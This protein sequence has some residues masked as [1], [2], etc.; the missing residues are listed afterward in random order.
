[1][2]F[3]IEWYQAYRWAGA[4][5]MP[6]PLPRSASPPAFSEESRRGLVGCCVWQ[7]RVILQIK[8]C[9]EKRAVVASRGMRHCRCV[10]P[11]VT[12][13]KHG[14]ITGSLQ[15]TV[16]TMTHKKCFCAHTSLS[17]STQQT[18][19]SGRWGG[20]GG[21]GPG[22]QWRCSRLLLRDRVGH[23]VVRLGLHSNDPVVSI[24][25]AAFTPTCALVTHGYRAARSQIEHALPQCANVRPTACLCQQRR[26]RRRR[27]LHVLTSRYGH[28]GDRTVDRR[29]QPELLADALS[30][31]GN[32]WHEPPPMCCLKPLVT[33]MAAGHTTGALLPTEDV[34][35]CTRQ[36]STAT[37]T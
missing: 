8:Q 32:M 28:N 27:G 19:R 10:L 1:M 4:L 12:R 2:R 11:A 25:D 22:G 33:S 21:I 17:I 29:T 7:P 16:L 37:V 3:D 18:Y 20:V 13:H 35:T 9:H 5:C 23:L 26:V 30:Q 24:T 34:L 36:L 31:S 15:R 6:P 14:I